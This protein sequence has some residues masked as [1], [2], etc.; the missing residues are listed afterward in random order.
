MV[1]PGEEFTFR[2]MRIRAVAAYNFPTGSSTRKV[3]RR[4]DGVGYVLT[5][6]GKAIYH[7][8]DTDFIPEMTTL[9]LVH[10]ALRPIGGTFT[11]NYAEAVRAAIAIK[12][13]IVI[14]MHRNKADPLMFKHKLEE[15]T[16]IKVVPLQIG[17]TY[18][19]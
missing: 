19:L 2:G 13:Q 14:P 1:A 8:G 7:A 5:V 3:H 9:G 17:E 15:K 4:G 11:M 16:K 6:E 12:P 18:Q 10:A